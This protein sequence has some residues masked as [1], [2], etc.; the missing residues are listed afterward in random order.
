MYS[1]IACDVTQTLPRYHQR[2]LHKKEEKLIKWNYFLFSIFS[3]RKF[4]KVEIGGGNSWVD[5]DLML[6]IVWRSRPA[7]NTQENDNKLK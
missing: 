6:L 2:L 3:E 4:W 5:D 1:F 7:L